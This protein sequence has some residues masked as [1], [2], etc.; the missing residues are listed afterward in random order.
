MNPFHYFEQCSKYKKDDFKDLNEHDYNLNS[1]K[2]IVFIDEL[3][4]SKKKY[5]IYLSLGGCYGDKE[6]KDFNINNQILPELQYLEE[7]TPIYIALDN[8][9]YMPID[10]FNKYNEEDNINLFNMYWFDD[11]TNL[12]SS[13]IELMKY[14]IDSNGVII[15]ANYCKYKVYPSP[16]F[17][18]LISIFYQDYTTNYEFENKYNQIYFSG[19]KMKKHIKYIEKN[20][21]IFLEWGGFSCKDNLN[22]YLVGSNNLIYKNNK[23]KINLIQHVSDIENFTKSNEVYFNISKLIFDY[24]L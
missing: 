20:R 19:I 21:A 16:L 1:E 24:A 2:L 13:F 12:I 9:N 5:W 4:K 17:S 8:F 18:N 11:D 10:E 22:L 15:C 23:D 3:I 14:N 6:K 7:Y